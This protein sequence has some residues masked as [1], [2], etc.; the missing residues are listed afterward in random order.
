MKSYS[1]E[2]LRRGAAGELFPG[3][4][5]PEAA[6]AGNWLALGDLDAAHRTAQEIETPEGSYWH[7]IMHR[8]EP[9]PSNSAYWF[10]RTGRHAI[11]PAL[12]ERAS[13][14]LEAYPD[15]KFALKAEW[16]P[17]AFIDFY[18]MARRKPGSREKEL[19]DV[20]ERI[21]WELL[22]DYCARPPE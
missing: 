6:V 7:A 18:E 22:F 5:A 9:D 8:R 15:V 1:E 11:F 3:A 2:E 12:R 16:D 4:R 10:G 17:Y 13:E 14:A 21:E 19:S 20:I